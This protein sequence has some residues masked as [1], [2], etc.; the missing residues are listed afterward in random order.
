[1]QFFSHDG[2]DLAYLDRAPED[3]SGD[4]VLMIHGFA[5]SHYVNWVGP[6]WFKTLNEAGYRAIAIDNRGHGASVKTYDGADYT[7]LKMASDAAAL[8]DHLGIEMSTAR[9]ADSRP[10]PLRFLIDSIYAMRPIE[11]ARFAPLVIAHRADPVAAALLAAAEGYL[12]KDFS[13]VFDPA[14]PAPVGLGGGIIPHLTG[15]PDAI[16]RLVREA[17]HTPDVRLVTDGSVGAVVLVLRA[18]GIAV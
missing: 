9:G 1:M 10:V 5:S 8:L 7:P 15:L 14:M 18:A 17:G 6:G 13:M 16:A 2:F 4:P 3:G 11:L 12:L